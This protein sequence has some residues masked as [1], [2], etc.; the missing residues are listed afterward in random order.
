MDII[1]NG[2]PLHQSVYDEFSP[3]MWVTCKSC[4]KERLQ[5][6]KEHKKREKGEKRK[7]KREEIK[8]SRS[9]RLLLFLSTP[10]CGEA[11]VPLVMCHN[12]E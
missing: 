3:L 7:Q 1:N 2:M 6:E 8:R 4:I 12:K 11:L 9:A 10:S 5:M